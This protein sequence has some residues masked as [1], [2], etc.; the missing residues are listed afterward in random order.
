MI[1]LYLM[2]KL[3]GL[4][5]YVIIWFVLLPFRIMLLP[6]KFLKIGLKAFWE[7]ITFPLQM[8]IEPIKRLLE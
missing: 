6:F 8:V 4:L 7:M 5:I 1:T 2:K 3:V